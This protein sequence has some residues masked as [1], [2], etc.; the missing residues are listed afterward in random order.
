VDQDGGVIAKGDVQQGNEASRSSNL[1][2]SGDGPEGSSEGVG[3]SFLSVLSIHHRVF[4][5]KSMHSN[6]HGWIV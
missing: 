4:E 2:V 5:L 3:V 1:H 6:H